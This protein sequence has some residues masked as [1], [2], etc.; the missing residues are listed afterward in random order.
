MSAPVL[1]EPSSLARVVVTLVGVVAVGSLVAGVT[2]VGPARL[3]GLFRTV[4]VHLREAAPYLAALI[5]VLAISSVA[6]DGL[7]SVSQLYGLYL[8]GAI[9][10]IEGEFV[11]W[12]QSYATEELTQLFSWV[13]VYGYA[14]L[15]VF[16]FIAYAALEESTQLERL[17]VAYTINYALGLLI[18]TLVFAHGPR[19]VMPDLV[20][21][22]LFT[23][24]P[25]FQR[26]VSH[27]NVH[28]NVFPSLHTSL[29]VTVALLAYRTREVYPAWAALA[30]VLAAGV[31]FSTMYLGIHWAIDVLGGIV[32]AFGSVRAACRYVDR[33]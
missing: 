6:R 11:G 8:T 9:F 2:I 16:P 18:Y 19:N 12:L 22:L 28:S 27:V 14:F 26:L 17:I 13:Y 10:A 25:E 1:P 33:D 5:L 31:V 32:L 24:T 4:P 20:T 15:L 21:S 29:S 7:Q 23:T 30:G 3:R